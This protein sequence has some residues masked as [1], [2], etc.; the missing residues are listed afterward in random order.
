MQGTSV[1]MYFDG[2]VIR[3]FV[4]FHRNDVQL[5]F[6]AGINDSGRRGLMSSWERACRR[7]LRENKT[8]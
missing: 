2:F 5:G 6:L 8:Q 1:R 7:R 4:L 3:E